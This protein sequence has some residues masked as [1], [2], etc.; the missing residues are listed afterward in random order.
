MTAAVKVNVPLT[1]G[2]P[3]RT[4]LPADRVIPVGKLPAVIDQLYAGIP[5]VAC[6]VCEYAVPSEAAASEAVVIVS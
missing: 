4:P 1:L 5:P 2:V 6:N 3:E